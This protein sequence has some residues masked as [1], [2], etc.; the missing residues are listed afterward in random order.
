MV[1]DTGPPEDGRDRGALWPWLA[2]LVPATLVAYA[3]VYVAYRQT[4]LVG[5]HSFKHGA[6][7]KLWGPTP[8]VLPPFPPDSWDHLDQGMV[9]VSFCWD[10]RTG[11]AWFY[12]L[13][14]GLVIDH[15]LT[16]VGVEAVDS[17][18]NRMGG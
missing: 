10:G 1:V 6:P 16:G 17:R 12:F 15:N 2:A 18:D 4:H 11:R 8:Y 13:Y 14:P 7:R 3:A 9:R 5:G